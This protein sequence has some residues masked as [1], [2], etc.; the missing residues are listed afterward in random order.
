[1]TLRDRR[2]KTLL[3]LGVVMTIVAV[4]F[5][6]LDESERKAGANEARTESPSPPPRKV[7]PGLSI[8]DPRAYQGY[9]LLAPMNRKR[10]YLIDM[11]GRVAKT[12]ES[13]ASPA[14]G[15]SL[16]AGG[17]LLR[18]A[19]ENDQPLTVAPGGG[20]LIQEFDW[21]GRLVWN[22]NYGD[23][24]H[25]PHH[26][27]IK[28]PSGNVLMIVWDRKTSKEAVDAGRIPDR[29]NDWPLQADCLVEVK[30][31]GPTTGEVVWEW[32]LWDHLIQDHDPD[33]ANY[34]D[35][36]AHPERVD[37]NFE[38][39]V[40]A[41]MLASPAGIDKL[42]SIGYLGGAPAAKPSSPINPDWTHF[43][44]VDYNP[45]LDQ[46]AIGVHGFSEVWIIDHGTT[47]AEASGHTG[48]RAGKGGDLLYRWGNPLAYRTG[49][50]DD[51][52]L[53]HQHNAHWI[54]EGLPGAG[55]LL[56]FNNG[57]HRPGVEHSSVE[58]IVLPVD[59]DGRYQQAVGK[60]FGP[61]GSV[62]SYSAPKKSDFYSP[63]VSGA[64]RLPNGDTLICSGSDGT[65]FEVTTAGE[66]V[67]KY[68]NGLLDD[69]TPS[70]PT[71]GHSLPFSLDD[72]L[73]LT[74]HQRND[75]IAFRKGLDETLKATLSDDQR[76][77]LDKRAGSGPSSYA[78]PGQLMATSTRITLKLSPDQKA[79][80][81]GLQ[82]Q[83]DQKL[84]S[85]LTVDQK[86][87]LE[88]QRDDFAHGHR[89]G[90]PGV[91]SGLTAAGPVVPGDPV[92]NSVGSGLFRAYRYG[93][94]D[95]E[96]VD[97]DLTSVEDVK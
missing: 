74:E 19:R 77:R 81:D 6:R 51:R 45:A 92:V 23:D 12:W 83:I 4:A 65:I 80:L 72:T 44:S 24:A 33:K 25:C 34:G 35:V 87:R 91:S 90:S 95:P 1:M 97:K 30:P 89:G 15:A 42:R 7:K 40:M 20:G 8:N 21:D 73:G 32:H 55:H 75:L 16:L 48:G 3:G 60:P 70:Q 36:A 69:A 11:A 27:A 82:E 5:V 22:F 68:V 54:P 10:T 18:P 94:D 52:K 50:A 28:L 47:T 49:Q 76:K 93:S 63:V 53:F 29:V 13:N 46:I 41:A 2:G 39:G 14:L 88:R 79:T 37:V 17:H 84:E 62:W 43:N 85:L 66:L 57:I 71:P 9:T 61:V 96:L 64:Q 26:E 86:A 38:E 56:V 67:W 58:E 59:P 78:P 31:T